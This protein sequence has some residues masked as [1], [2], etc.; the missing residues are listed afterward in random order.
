MMK[1]MPMTIDQVLQIPKIDTSRKKHASNNETDKNRNQDNRFQPSEM[2][3]LRQPSTPF[4]VAIVTLDD[5]IIINEN[6]QEAD[7]HMVTGPSKN[8]PRQSSNN[9]NTTNTVRPSAD[10]LF[11]ENPEPSDP[12]NQIAQAVEKLARENPEPSIFHPKNTLTFNGKLEKNEKFEYIEDLFRTTLKM[13]PQ[14]TEEMKINNFHAHLR[15]LA[16]KTFKF[17]QRTPTTT[18]E[19]ILIV[20]RRKYVKPESSASAKHRFNRLMF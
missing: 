1:R 10:H 6:R 20:F 15:G 12:V 4:W 19:D 11:L 13:Q 18:L 16:L 2:H 9:S 7:Y 3:E 14:L 8:I 17:I 5:T